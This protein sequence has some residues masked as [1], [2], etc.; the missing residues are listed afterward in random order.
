MLKSQEI[1]LA[2]SKRREKM[3]EIQKADEITDD[4]RTELRSLTSAYEGAEVELRAALLVEGAERDKIKEPDRAESDFD[5]EC[6]AFNLSGMVASLTEGK[7]LTGREAEVSAELENRHGD[8]QKGV[9][10]PWESL[11]ETRADVATDAST[12]VSGNL[13]SRPTMNAL[14]RFFEASAAQRFGVSALQVTGAPSFPEITG[15][16]GLSWVAEGGGADA[17]AI[18]T[19]AVSP[20]IHTATG[21]YLLTRQAIRQNSALEAI[22]RRDL[23]EVLREGMDLAVFQ[24][25]GADEQPAGF[26]TVLTGGRTAAL[27]DVAS[28]SE[29]LLR[30]TE[31]QETAKL[32]DPS[33]V[34]V[35]G[36]PIVHQTLA[37]TLVSGTAVSELDRL[38]GAG[39]G[40]MWSSQVSTRGARDGTDK[41]ASSVYFG[42]GANNAFVPTWGSPELLVDPYSESKTGKVALTMFAFVDVLIQRTA[43]HYFKL[44]G[45]QDRA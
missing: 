19:T 17:A 26:E 3:A 28:F 35:A 1:Q 7:P 4:A 12:S 31:I 8:G 13:A 38:K 36:A 10:F 30:A 27:D 32:S 9:R 18:S 33:G 34:R 41:G 6:R 25:T 16:T 20:A 11:L 2:Q 24:G 23:S 14:E 45:V 40:M 37:D 42:A 39:F 22:L 44:T 43:T 21:R 5:R 29:F 15:G